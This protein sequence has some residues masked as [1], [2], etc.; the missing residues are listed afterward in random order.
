MKTFKLNY[1]LFLVLTSFILSCSGDDSDDVGDANNPSGIIGTW[2]L[3]QEIEFV[4]GEQTYVY[5]VPDNCDEE[6]LSFSPSEITYKNDDDCDGTFD[7][8]DTFSY[9]ISG[10]ELIVGDD[11][12]EITEVTGSI[13]KLRGYLDANNYDEYIYEKF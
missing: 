6:I 2:R 13:L 12:I 4:D 8:I 11:S 10:N 7:E 5:N 9:T 1:I 3:A